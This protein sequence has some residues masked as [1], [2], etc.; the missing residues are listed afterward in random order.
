MKLKHKFIFNERSGY[1]LMETTLDLE[2]N[3]QLNEVFPS[4]FLKADDLQGRD[5]PVVIAT[6]GLEQIGNNERKLVLTFQGKNKGMICNKTNANR[7]AFLHGTETDNWIG[8]EIILTVDMVDFQG[9]VVPA[10][11]VKPARP[12]VSVPIRKI[13]AAPGPAP[14]PE[15]QGE[16]IPF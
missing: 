16:D 9:R 15:D 2:V 1:A 11:R 12:K 3:M 6:A 5:V 14:T 13:V 7:I 8:K 4:N 10:I